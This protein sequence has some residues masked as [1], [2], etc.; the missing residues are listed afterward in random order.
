MATAVTR[1]LNDLQKKLEES[2]EPE[3][4][5][6]AEIYKFNSKKQLQ[7][8]TVQQFLTN[9][10]KLSHICNFGANLQNAIGNQ[11]VYGLECTRTRQRLLETKKLELE[12]AVQIAVAM[13]LSKKENTKI[14][15]KVH[16]N[17]ENLDLVQES[18]HPF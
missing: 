15:N 18:K 13:Q 2:Y 7:G 16:S 14:N 3:C 6:M 9:L 17:L 11:F 1:S 10:K 12:N 4:I 5:E 8:E